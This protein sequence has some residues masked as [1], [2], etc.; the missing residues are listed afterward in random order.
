MRAITVAAG[1]A[2]S[3]RL[4]DWPDVRPGPGELL[5]EALSLGICGTD[6]EIIAAEY[7]QAPE[8]EQR[9]V[10]GH[11]SLGRV[12]TA[13]EGCGFQVGDL[14][15]GVVRRPDPIPC[16]ACAGGEWDMCRNGLYTERGIKA[17]HGYGSERYALEPAFAIHVDP[18]LGRLGVLIE[19][20][21]VVAKAWDHIERIGARTRTWQPKTLLVTGGGPVGLLAAMIGRQKG[22]QTHLLDHA[23]DGPK[24]NLVADLGA[25]FHND[26]KVIADLTPDILVECTGADELVLQALAHTGED[27]IVC[28]VGLSAAGRTVDFDVG[29]FNRR[30]V[31]RNDVVFGSVNANR[32]H[33]Q[34]AA[35]ALARADAAWLSRL[36]S[37][38]VPLERWSEAFE[39]R[40]HDVKVVIDFQAD[41]A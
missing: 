28:L 38:R 13:P 26:P 15:V 31:L 3:V 17:R 10:L 29:G 36:I 14:V 24:P 21:S 1:Q 12:L 34:A 23:K 6:R 32:A 20:T 39:D 8:G 35:R 5:V 16:P 27:A 11:E 2:N 7:G 33:Y 30:M 9:L 41:D 40:P 4:D 19:P 18:A 25:R 22:L 37:R